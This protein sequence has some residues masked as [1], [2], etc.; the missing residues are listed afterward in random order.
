MIQPSLHPLQGMVSPRWGISHQARAIADEHSR[1]TAI[2]RV[3][4]LCIA[5]R[6]A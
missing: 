6:L 3:H 5:S 1:E 2:V 4:I